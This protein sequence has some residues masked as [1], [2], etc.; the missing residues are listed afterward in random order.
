MV[1]SG[2][3]FTDELAVANLQASNSPA[4]ALEQE[5]QA[6]A[7]ACTVRYLRTSGSYAVNSAGVRASWVV[8]YLQDDDCT[9]IINAVTHS[10]SGQAVYWHLTTYNRPISPPNG[11]YS[12]GCKS[13]GS[14]SHNFGWRVNRGGLI[15][16]ET[17]DLSGCSF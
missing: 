1:L 13:Y 2:D 4:P 12:M 10:K 3:P 11:H 8:N 15:S 6:A 17:R 16:F 9:G 5:Q 7:A 14:T